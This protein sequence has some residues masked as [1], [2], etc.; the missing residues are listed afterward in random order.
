MKGQAMTA[1]TLPYPDSTRETLQLY[2]DR[3]V[4]HLIRQGH[5][6][7]GDPLR[8]TCVYRAPDGSRCAVGFHIPDDLLDRLER[9]DQLHVA[10]GSLDPELFEGVA[11]PAAEGMVDGVYGYRLA[12]SLQGVHDD[13]AAWDEEAGFV[14]WDALEDV[15]R[16]YG[17]SFVRP[18][19][20]ES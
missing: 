16:W 1:T 12:S 7:V 14:G 4:E 2:F 11:W 15:A 19:A 8:G 5:R 17:L 18:E 9:D 20:V 3:T 6:A 13:Y 10:I